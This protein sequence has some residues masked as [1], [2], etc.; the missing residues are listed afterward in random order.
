[1][2]ARNTHGKDDQWQHPIAGPRTRPASA[3]D[4]AAP[5]AVDM[6]IAETAPPHG[7]IERV[8]PDKYGWCVSPSTRAA[9][10]V[11]VVAS[12]GALLCNLLPSKRGEQLIWPGTQRGPGLD[13]V[14]KQ[15]RPFCV[16]CVALL[17]ANEKLFLQN[18][19]PAFL[20]QRLQEM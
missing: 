2:G 13:G 10:H 11:T 5:E 1:M 4:T 8:N 7:G 3:P 14:V 19:A 17:N 16:D 12:G 6:R 18:H 15:G 20:V 9:V